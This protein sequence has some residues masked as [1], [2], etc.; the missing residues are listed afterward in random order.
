MESVVVVVVLVL[1]G[2]LDDAFFE[3]LQLTAEIIML[4]VIISI[5]S[6]EIVLKMG[7]IKYILVCHSNEKVRLCLITPE[8]I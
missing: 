1:A 2:V 6:R 8:I 4:I 3:E 7:F 5:H